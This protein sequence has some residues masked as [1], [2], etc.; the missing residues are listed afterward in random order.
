[1]QAVMCEFKIE[2]LCL[3]ESS[4]IRLDN[5]FT[6][7]IFAIDYRLVQTEPYFLQINFDI[8]FT[9]TIR[10]LLLFRNNSYYVKSFS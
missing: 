4:E 5:F 1:M 9:I 8:L 7:K 3:K 2:M 10:H 6:C